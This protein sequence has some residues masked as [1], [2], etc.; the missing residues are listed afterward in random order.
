MASF[1]LKIKYKKGQA[2]LSTVQESTT[3]R[4]LKQELAKITRIVEDR[5]HVLGGFPPKPLDLSE[6]EKTLG[7]INIH[8]GDTLIIEEKPVSPASQ[9][10]C[11]ES[12]SALADEMRRHTSVDLDVPGVLLKKVVPADNSCLFTS[13]GFTLRGQVDISVGAYMRQVIAG[14]LASDP[15]KYNEAFLGRPNAEYCN[16]IKKP[17]SWGG[18]IELA[19]LSKFYGLEIAVVDTINAII[20]R[21]GEDQSYSHRVFLIFDGIHYDPL[22][23]EPLESTGTIQT[24]FPTSDEKILH[25]A[26]TL[27]REAQSSRQF[28]DVDKFSLKCN[29]CGIYLVGQT[30]ALKHAKETGHSSFGE[31]SR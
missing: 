5:L 26:E 14:E 1:V 23:L 21:F 16:W 18:A 13:L 31:V 30:E 19:I 25:E 3:I 15:D 17:E 27:A 9:S 11:T 12:A 24:I 29:E 7:E 20:N 4:V 6:D 22:Y 28:T 2:V 8:S 10:L